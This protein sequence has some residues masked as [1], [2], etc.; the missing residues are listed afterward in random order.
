M[1]EL[2]AWPAAPAGAAPARTARLGFLLD[3]SEKQRDPFR[4]PWVTDSY[5]PI[6]G[7]L[8]P[9]RKGSPTPV[10]VMGWEQRQ[11]WRFLP[12]CDVAEAFGFKKAVTVF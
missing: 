4:E 12:T 1:R 3:V 6:T 2:G 7:F 9:L 8:P 11:I 5:P 10:P